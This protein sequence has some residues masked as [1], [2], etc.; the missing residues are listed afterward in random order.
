MATE[1]ERPAELAQAIERSP[2]L[3]EGDDERFAGYGV[4]AAPFSSG[5]LL[6][7]RRFPAS[8]LGGGYTT[9]WHR[10]T[11]G[12]WTIWSDRPP[13]ETCPR[14]FG[15]ALARAIET[16]IQVTWSG[17]RSLAI[18][19][20]AADLRWT[21][22]L[23]ATGTAR[24][25]TALGKALPDRFWRSPR[26]LAMLA[27]VAGRML[28][29]GKLQLAGR[30]PNGQTFVANPMLLWTIASSSAV[31]AG[32]DFGELAPL[33]EQTHLGDFWLPQRGIFAI[34]RAFFEPLDAT[35]HRVVPQ[36]A[37]EAAPR[38]EQAPPP[39]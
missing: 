3:P 6:A 26:A 27:R 37:S 17:P 16:P 31:L 29:A 1:Y 11:S 2:S 13:L 38:T 10:A 25:L 32:R 20:P 28:H 18:E 14:Y 22:E 5:D 34:G 33:P 8:S 39:P 19:V 23:E 21:L 15:S 4:M 36:A 7:M 12:E 24:L 9:V 35:R 30:V